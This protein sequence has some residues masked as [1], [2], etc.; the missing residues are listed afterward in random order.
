MNRPPRIAAWI[1]LS[2]FASALAAVLVTRVLFGIYLNS[3]GFRKKIGAAVAQTLK[4]D[5]TFMPFHFSGPSIYSDGFAARG[6][7]AFFTELR[8]EQIRADFNWRGLL[9]RSWQIDQLELQRLDITFAEHRA[10]PELRENRG[11]AVP[12]RSDGW[13]VDLRG[14]SVRESQ[15]TWGVGTDHAGGVNG[16]GL[17]LTPDGDAWLI[18]AQ[19]GKL[20]QSGWP[21]LRL[22]TARLRYQPGSLF[23]LDSLFRQGTGSI[24][25]S[26]EIAFGS[27]ADMRVELAGID[28][29][30]MLPADWRARLSG[31]LFGDVKV[32]A[33]LGSDATDGVTVDGPLRLADGQLTALP[34]LDQISTFTR[35]QRFRQMALS[36]ATADVSRSIERIEARNIV[37][38]SEGLMRVEGQC[39]IANGAID[40]TFQVGVTPASLQWIPGSRARVFT[41]AR[42]GY[43]WTP[44]RLTGSADHPTEDLTPR[45]VA[46]AA[47]EVIN[48]VEGSVRDTTKGVLDLL[49]H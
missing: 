42:G 49:L 32:R 35:T 17:R 2:L 43:L 30:P 5:G 24:K 29:N 44:M 48:D 38:E 4:A 41:V 11:G 47:D 14:A 26:G 37:L 1:A 34:M 40:G 45:L 19:G 22:E 16:A 46:A 10:E 27:L 28:V 31:K 6:T 25:T 39:S 36:K 13:K 3:E 9:H 18:D 20:V 8:A 21:E 12:A 33:P 7:E 15:W 23:I